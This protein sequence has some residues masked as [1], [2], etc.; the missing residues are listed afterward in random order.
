MN[1]VPVLYKSKRN[2]SLFG[3]GLQYQLS[4]STQLY[5]NISQAYRPYLYANVTPADRVD[6][7]DPNLKDSKGYD[8]DLGYRGHYTNVL[9]FDVNGYYLFYGNRVGL[10]SR[11]NTDGTSFLL[12]T[13]IG[14]S[15]AKGVEAYLEISLLKLINAPTKDYDITIF[16]S[17]AY[18]HARYTSGEINKAGINT[19]VKGNHVE[20]VPDWI[21][22]CGVGFQ[23]KNISMNFQYSY[24]S[25]TYDDAFNTVESSN[26]VT[27]LIPAYHLWDW[28][29]NWQLSKSFHL[30]AGINNFTN[31][32]YFN[33]RIT[34]YPGPGILP[35]DGRTFFVSFGVE[36]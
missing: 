12:T 26:G 29:F 24:T 18:D 16:N 22:K 5:G 20:N 14:N 36:I 27:G 32:K 1:N 33:R 15:V 21:N 3:A 8:I 25:K 13:N 7:I 31:E 34:M 23:I 35:A 2:F 19:S 6:K 17:L 11:Q 9:R 10:L 4:Q 28:N 30:S